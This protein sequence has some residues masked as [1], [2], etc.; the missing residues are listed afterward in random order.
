MP[1]YRTWRRETHHQ[2]HQ[3]VVQWYVP[4]GSE[5]YSGG[6]HWRHVFKPRRRGPFPLETAMHFVKVEKALR[7][8]RIRDSPGIQWP[9]TTY[10]LLNVVTNEVIMGDI[11]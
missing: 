1:K 11:L 5:V 4:K 6:S 8:Q 2:G 7:E 3:W 10:R 9:A